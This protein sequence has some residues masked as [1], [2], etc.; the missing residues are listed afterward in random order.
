M[1][2]KGQLQNKV[3]LV[4]GAGQGIGRATA[5]R[6]AEEGAKVAV[7]D[8]DTHPDLQAVARETGGIAV[9]CD[10]SKACQVETMVKEI[11][12]QLGPVEILVANAAYMTMVP[13]LEQDPG[14]WWK[15]LNVNLTGHL[16]CIQAVLA[17]MRKLGGGRIIIMSS[18]FGI[19]GWK[20]A[21]AYGASKSGLTALGEALAAELRSENIHVGIVHPGVIDTPQ[22]QVD[23][24]DFDISLDEVKA[25]YA[26][27][28]PLDRV[29][30]P[31]EV[32]ATV[33]FLAAEG[34]PIFSGQIVQIN[35]GLSR[36]SR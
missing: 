16:G 9:A 24:D 20:N 32:A 11:A 7:N 31:E 30:D 18:M 10:M 17:G 4:T 19:E 22:L 36:C 15:H 6:L 23:A 1:T 35:G 29:G 26:K 25:M 3:A 27:D 12:E 8:L 2:F 13:F 34:G 5:I 28:I 14:D 33:S 21:S